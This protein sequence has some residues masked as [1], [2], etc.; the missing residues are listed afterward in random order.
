MPQ[1]PLLEG[2]LSL[3]F[4]DFYL[5]THRLLTVISIISNWYLVVGIL[6]GKDLH[7]T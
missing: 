1:E 3:E 7:R 4:P 2:S 5:N 6:T